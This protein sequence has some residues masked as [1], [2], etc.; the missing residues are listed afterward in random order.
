MTQN[1]KLTL[2]FIRNPFTSREGT[3][4]TVA[5]F[6]LK[7]HAEYERFWALEKKEIV[8]FPNGNVLEVYSEV[9]SV[10]NYVHVYDGSKR[11]VSWKA[12]SDVDLMFLLPSGEEAYVSLS[13]EGKLV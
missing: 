5:T 11:L 13:V 7:P 8:T 3:L 10:C 6:L 2:R 12:A 4:E 9:N 1:P